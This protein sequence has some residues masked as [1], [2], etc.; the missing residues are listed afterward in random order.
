M[1]GEHVYHYLEN[2]IDTARY[3]AAQELFYEWVENL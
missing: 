1:L 3:Y 2:D